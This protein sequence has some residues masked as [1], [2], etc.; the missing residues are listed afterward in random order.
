MKISLSEQVWLEFK[1]ATFGSRSIAFMLDFLIRWTVFFLILILFAY[2]SIPDLII[3][4]FFNGLS[5][6]EGKVKIFLIIFFFAFVEFAYNIGFEV[7]NHGVTPGKKIMSL[8]V[9]DENGLPISLKTSFLRNLLTSVDILPGMGI[10]AFMS[11][12]LSKKSQR[13]GDLVAKTIVIHEL[14]HKNLDFMIESNW[15]KAQYQLPSKLYSAL[16]NFNKR[17][18][19]FSKDAINKTETILKETVIEHLPKIDQNFFNDQNWTEELYINSR[20]TKEN[21]SSKH[22]TILVSHEIKN[23]FLEFKN[24]LDIYE[25][26]PSKFS[27]NELQNLANNYHGICHR[28]AY[29]QTFYPDTSETQIASNLLLRARRLIYGRRLSSY[30]ES[31]GVKFIPRVQN[32]F[33]K[34]WK[35]SVFSLL[36]ASTS[37]ILCALFIQIHPVLGWNFI[38]EETA[39]LLQSGHLWTE[40]IQGINHIA[41]S[42]IMT[43][44][45]KVTFSAFALGVTGGIGTLVVLI[46]NGIHLGGIFSVLSQY[47]MAH[48]L[49]NFVVAHGFLELSVIFVAGGCG[50]YLGDAI[51]KPGNETRKSALG[52]RGK[53]VVDLIIFNS[54]CLVLAGFVEG[55]ISP[56][57]LHF[58][59]KLTIGVILGAT[60][61]LILCKN[62]FTKRLSL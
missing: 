36:L 10:V 33:T 13:L 17:K 45:I 54:I 44:N 42:E 43:N 38:N 62:L 61:W 60:Y 22:D 4:S 52:K 12:L 7:F 49:L 19:N 29:L 58:S 15:N 56:S 57:E 2:I 28:Y 5:S 18:R 27:A 46:F 30:H 26:K 51:L 50:L 32:S 41:S 35:H 39:N 34:V 48:R 8:R 6:S 53:E 23:E 14:N 21:S 31:K 55:Y 16:E 59:L 40:N 37:G 9:V 20:P 11:M 24:L 47:D 3:S 1:T 25:N